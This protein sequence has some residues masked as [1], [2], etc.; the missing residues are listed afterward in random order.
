M[1]LSKSLLVKGAMAGL[2][3]AGV[4]AISTAAVAKTYVVCNQYDECWRVH[5][6]YTTYPAD[7][8]IVYH[9]DAW[10]ATHEHDTHVHYRLLADPTD[11]HGWYDKDGVWHPFAP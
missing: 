5:E 6:H 8:K 10:W 3:S 2:V 7:V 11:D 1:T 4:L 9:D